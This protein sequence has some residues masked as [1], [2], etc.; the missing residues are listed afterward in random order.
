MRLIEIEADPNQKF[1]VPFEGENIEVVLTYKDSG[2]WVG[3][4]SYQNKSING[5]TLA[6]RVL[7]LQG[8]NLPFDFVIDDKNADLD[9]YS[10]NSFDEQ[11]SMYLLEREDMIKIRGYDVK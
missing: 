1:L 11:F 5:I 7:L 8:L 4:F 9:P 2:F 10:L 6:S 3:N